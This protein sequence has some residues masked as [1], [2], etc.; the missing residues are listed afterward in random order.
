[1]ILPT[2]DQTEGIWIT[3]TNDQGYHSIQ[4]VFPKETEIDQAHRANCRLLIQRGSLQPEYD[5]D[6]PHSRMIGGRRERYCRKH[7]Y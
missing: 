7:I 4:E 5:D 2:L 3:R 6:L 1:M